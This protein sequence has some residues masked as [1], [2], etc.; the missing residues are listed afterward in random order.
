[1]VCL[2]GEAARY[3]VV[4]LLLHRAALHISSNGWAR[5]IQWARFLKE[6]EGNEWIEDRRVGMDEIRVHKNGLASSG[7]E[8]SAE[9][10]SGIDACSAYKAERERWACFYWAGR[11]EYMLLGSAGTLRGT[12]EWCSIKC[13]CASPKWKPLGR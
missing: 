1:M 2:R 5:C 4:A 9:Q 8:D 11:E 12:A 7:L 10:H 13:P 3:G 6:R